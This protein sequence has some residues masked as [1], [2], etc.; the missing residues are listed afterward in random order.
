MRDD[1]VRTPLADHADDLL[2]VL[3]RR[4][5]FAIVNVEHLR[6]RADQC[7]RLLHFRESS[8]RKRAT[9]RLPVAD[10]TIRHRH[11]LH[12]MAELCPLRR[13]AA[14]SVLRIIRMRAK[15]DDPQLAIVALG[16]GDGGK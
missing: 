9:R 12:V 7:I 14:G 4:H 11:E 2:A 15:D 3:Q 10:V 5:Q 8:L 1:D 16:T 13:C 6:L